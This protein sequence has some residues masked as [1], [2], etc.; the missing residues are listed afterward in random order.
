MFAGSVA[1]T[2]IIASVGAARELFD[3][4][5]VRELD[6]AQSLDE[7]AAPNF[8]AHF[9][10]IEHGIQ[11]RPVAPTVFAF[12]TFARDDA[13]AR[14]IHACQFLGA[15]FIRHLPQHRRAMRERPPTLRL[16]D[17]WRLRRANV[18]RR[19]VLHRDNACA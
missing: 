2:T 8:A 1:L 19:A 18:L 11:H 14:K 5:F 16:R 13:I 6:A 17:S 9:P 3:C 7:I 12:Q 4:V 10:T 15:L